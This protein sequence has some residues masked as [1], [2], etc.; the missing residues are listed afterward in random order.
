MTT[1]KN[2]PTPSAPHAASVRPTTDS[3]TLAT[4]GPATSGTR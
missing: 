3:P 1:Q 2:N 4:N